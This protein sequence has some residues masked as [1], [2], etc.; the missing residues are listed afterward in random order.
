MAGNPLCEGD[1]VD[2]FGGKNDIQNKIIRCVGDPETRFSEDA[3]RIMR[4]V[5]FA[6][7]LDFSIDENTRKAASKMSEGLSSVSIERKVVELKKILLSDHADRGISL[8]FDLGLEKYIHKDLKLPCVPLSTLPKSFTTRL[9]ALFGTDKA[10]ELSFLKLSRQ[11]E[12]EIK[13]LCGSK[14]SD[15]SPVGARRLISR[16]GECAE[17][18]ALLRGDAQF[19]Q[20]ISEEKAKNPCVSISQLPINGNDLISIGIPPREIGDIMQE[21]LDAVIKEPEACKKDRLLSLALTKHYEK[22]KG[23]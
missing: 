15:L 8:L 6:T 7:T 14:Y 17:G 4:A 12:K 18:A 23:N 11:E 20:L 3:L 13:L 16:L 5:R 9:S 22:S 19:A 1:V 21:L 2:L 10:P